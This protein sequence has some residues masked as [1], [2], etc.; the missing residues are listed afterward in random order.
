MSELKTKQ[1]NASVP[2]FL[3]SLD[4]VQQ[5]ADCQ[6]MVAMMQDVTGEK[7]KMWGDAIVGF[8]TYHYKYA[9]GREGDWFLVGLSPRKRSLSIYLMSGF[10]PLGLILEK[11]GKFK[12]GKCC[13]YVNQ[14]DD[15][16]RKVL[17]QLITK[18]ARHVGKHQGC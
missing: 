2:R 3:K 4:D 18:S 8:G 5:R 11:L 7:P 1:N 9:S 16:D 13:L 14:L 6:E 12:T 17:K 15:I 10:E